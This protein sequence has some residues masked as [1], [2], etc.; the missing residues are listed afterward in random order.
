MHR[1]SAIACLSLL[2]FAIA[3]GASGAEGEPCEKCGLGV[4]VTRA[5]AAN[6]A[7]SNVSE[8]D[9][10]YNMSS[11][12]INAGDTVTW[13]NNGNAVHTSTSD[14]GVWDS[15]SMSPGAKFSQVFNSAG[16]FPYHCTF[17]GTTFNMKGTVT[18]NAAAPVA[19]VISS[20]NTATGTVGQNFTYTITA[21]NTPASFDAT[22]L[23]A[24]L[25]VN[26][27]TGV[28]SGV[29]AAAGPSSINISASNAGGMGSTTLALTVNNPP[30]PVINSAPTAAA[31][32]GAPFTYTITA[33]N[34]PTSFSAT[35]LPL[36]LSLNTAT[37]VISGLAQASGTTPI[38]IGATNAGGTGSATLTLVVTDPPPPAITSAGTASAALGIGFL[39]AITATNS[40]ASYSASGLPAGLT[41]NTS[42]GVISGSPAVTGTFTATLGA[43]NPG[44]TGSATLT[45]TVTNP[46]PPVITSPTAVTALLNM[47]FA[48]AITASNNPSSFNATGLPAGLTVT[49]NGNISGTPTSAG[50]F[51]V[52][53]SATNISGTG[54]ATLAL[55][56]IAG[57]PAAITSPL[58]AVAV[59]GV[60]FNYSITAGG[61]PANIAITATGVLPPGLTL[62]GTTITGIPTTAGTFVVTLGASN[63]AGNDSKSLTIV[64]SDPAAGGDAD[65]DGFPDALELLLGTSP[66]DPNS[67][68][69]SITQPS[70]EF[71]A[72]A[73]S[74]KLNFQKTGND[75]IT[76]SG[77]LTV[78]EGLSLSGQSVVLDL[79]GVVQS[80]TLDSRGSAKSGNN[81]FKLTAKGKNGLTIG[82]NSKFSAK[83][84]RGNFRDTLSNIGLAGTDDVKN[85]SKQ[86]TLII[87]FDKTRLQTTRPLTFTAK[88]GKTGTAK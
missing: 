87:L 23:P 4:A 74:I 40:P 57:V 42:T 80:F 64:V 58:S 45:I 30:A 86:I 53:I 52:N 83:L 51:N 76:L 11:I 70:K 47:S 78:L 88:K 65:G 34:S 6:R 81:T 17:H 35:G 75:S 82:G 61:V 67:T 1:M 41:V 48:Y 32:T 59:L 85:A 12:T 16:S 72:T 63:S 24:G 19:P 27:N 79:G 43:I 10:Q 25:S 14:T 5:A 20:A 2:V 22:G 31:T 66:T 21:T 26:Q 39:Y 37:G 38:S 44:G 28:I 55:N 18:V 54:S 15:G 33:T 49:S 3:T 84:T 7:V 77:S 71:L 68:P 13:T 73:I 29:P 50:T 62:S 60:P 9:F 8:V 69:F 36:S 46:P 56:I